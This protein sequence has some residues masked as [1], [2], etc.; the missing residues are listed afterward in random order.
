MIKTKKSI[1]SRNQLI[2]SKYK[3][4]FF[5]KKGSYAETYRVRDQNNNTKILKLFCYSQLDK[6]QFDK[7][8]DLVEIEVLKQLNHV[9]LLKFVENGQFE[10]EEEKYGYALV[11][12]ISG[13][14][15][16]EKM[17]RD[18]YINSYEAKEIILVLLEGLKCLHQ[19]KKPIIHN[20]ITDLNVMLDL[21][22]T[23]NSPRLID[24]GYARFLKGEK[25]IN[26]QELNI[27]YLSLIHI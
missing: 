14:T 21:S 2:D 12:F 19:L 27:F 25:N 7:N 13:E 11:D 5:L 10:L 15:L 24:F 9:N 1:F 22:A 23:T 8:D 26:K 3:V 18:N 6:S 17:A 16:A 4:D 20:E